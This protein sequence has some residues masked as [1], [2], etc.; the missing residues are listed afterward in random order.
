MET[1]LIKFEL[2]GVIYRVSCTVE[3]YYDDVSDGRC[4][5]AACEF[6]GRTFE[7]E[8]KS[9]SG[10]VS[11]LKRKIVEE[12]ERQHQRELVKL[13]EWNAGKAIESER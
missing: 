3:R 13:E 2:H 1:R 4:Y 11:E 6:G 8:G 12:I 10:G 5:Q 9:A 7:A